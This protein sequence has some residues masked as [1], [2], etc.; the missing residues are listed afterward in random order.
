MA[1]PDEPDPPDDRSDDRADERTV[2]ELI[3]SATLAELQRWF[4]LPSFQQVEEAAAPA[5]P[6]IDPEILAV[7]ERRAKALESV[8]PA[9]VEKHRVQFEVL[10][11]SYLKF[12]ATIELASEREIALLD[13]GMV[14]RQHTIAEPREVEISEQLR[15]DLRECAPQ[16]LLRDLHRPEIDFE[17]TFEVIDIAA[18]QRLDIVAEVAHVMATSWKL[19]PLEDLPSRSLA[20]TLR[21][22]H[23]ESWRLVYQQLASMPNRRVQ[24]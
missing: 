22:H 13:R 18:E 4:G 16:A 6:A 3:D 20:S 24:E 21:A 17:K 5:A 1:P 15:D 8:D 23:A 10:P 14:D 9:F 11:A 2:K 12:E 19:P 7:R